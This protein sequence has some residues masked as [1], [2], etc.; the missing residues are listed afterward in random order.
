MVRRSEGGLRE[1]AAVRIG[2][3]KLCRDKHELL[4]FTESG[5]R[6]ILRSGNFRQ[7]LL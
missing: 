1:E 6:G 7:I 4:N 5:L 2:A 3:P